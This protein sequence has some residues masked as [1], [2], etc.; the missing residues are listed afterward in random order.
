MV[1]TLPPSPMSI[2]PPAR[3]SLIAFVWHG[4]KFD[5]I[6][7][8]ATQGSGHVLHLALGALKTDVIELRARDP[9]FYPQ[10]PA[11]HGRIPTFRAFLADTDRQVGTAWAHA[12]GLGH[13]LKLRR[14][15]ADG[16]TQDLRPAMPAQSANPRRPVRKRDAVPSQH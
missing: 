14:D 16:T 13:R 9:S 5:E 8:A 2:M 10:G 7:T 6:G 3:P 1:V 12:D 4:D 15:I 11:A